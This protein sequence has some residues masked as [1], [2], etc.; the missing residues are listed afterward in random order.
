MSQLAKSNRAMLRRYLLAGYVLLIAYASLSP[1]SGWHEQGLEF[2]AV[3]TSPLIQTYS[4]FD[5]LSNLLAY[6]PFGMLLGLNC[7][8]RCG[9]DQSLLLTVL[10]G[11]VLSA[12]MEY[13][14]MYL[15]NRTSSNLD[16]ITNTLGTTIGASI[17]VFVASK[18]WFFRLAHWRIGVFE[19]EGRAELGMT[20]IV[21]WMFAQINP[22]L[23]MLGNV[24]IT[25][26]THVPFVHT[27]IEPFDIWECIAVA[28]NLTMVGTLLLLLLRSRRHAVGGLVF[29]L[30]T[31][32][33]FKFIAAAVLLKS[34]AL[35]LWLNSEAMFGIF[36]GGLLM[37]SMSWFKRS[38]IL[39]MAVLLAI[40]YLMLALWVLDSVPASTAM[41]LYQWH[42]GHL[43]NYNGLSQKVVLVFP[44][45]MLAYL[46]HIRRPNADGIIQTEQ[47]G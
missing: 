5:A 22:S 8:I 1:F 6:L 11:V 41:M 31:V 35:L 26:P 38:L 37:I 23:P 39:Q 3:L 20:L 25:A 16:I 4:W 42:F 15:P 18:T 17:A 43:L 30:C 32:A 33:V 27:P 29:M 14:Q 2:W 34:S 46:W 19:Q 36:L 40:A 7:R 13:L 21:L 24:F 9:N 10:G 47:E 28:L 45:L 12:T 44:V